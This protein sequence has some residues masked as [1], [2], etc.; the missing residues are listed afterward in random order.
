[1]YLGDYWLLS[2][3]FDGD[4]IDDLYLCD[5]SKYRGLTSHFLLN[6]NDY[7]FREAPANFM[8]LTIPE[9]GEFK[10][11]ISGDANGDGS[12]DIMWI[13]GIGNELFEITAM[14]LDKTF[15]PLIIPLVDT[16]AGIII[17]GDMNGDNYE[18]IC[19]K[20]MSGTFAGRTDIYINKHDFSFAE[21][22]YGGLSW[23]GD[24]IIWSDDY[25][26]DGLDDLFVKSGGSFISGDWYIMSNKP[27]G[28]LIFEIQFQ[29]K[30]PG[31]F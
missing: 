14:N 3:D 31:S 4:G 12:D 2:G 9:K 22:Y 20:Y 13:A 11:I 17:A 7:S 5:Y 10:K 27:S 6:N 8:E 19:V 1:M 18:D 30:Y 23:A 29:I 26:G 15:K 16:C 24:Y 28:G 21:P 25:D